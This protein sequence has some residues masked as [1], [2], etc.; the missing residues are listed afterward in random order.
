MVSLIKD[1]RLARQL[2]LDV[3]YQAEIRDQLPAEALSLQRREG[4]SVT[5]GDADQGPQE[6]PTE[7]AVSYASELV[8]GVQEHSAEIDRLIDRYAERWAL[9]RM[10]VVDRNLLR[11]AVFELLWAPGVPTAVVINEAIELAKSLSTEE[12]GRFIN[13]V[14]GRLA[15]QNAP[16]PEEPS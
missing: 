6:P 10:P 13:G 11:V 9:E 14:L 15:E 2:A 8:E 16:A 1:R 7:E 12:S 3:L 5:L 4:W